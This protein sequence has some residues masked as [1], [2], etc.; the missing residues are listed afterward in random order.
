MING[1]ALWRNADRF[2]GTAPEQRLRFPPKPRSF[3][4][5]GF[6]GSLSLSFQ[7]LSFFTH[8]SRR[9]VDEIRSCFDQN[10]SLYFD[11]DAF[12]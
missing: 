12:S 8:V 2:I 6:Q 7:A 4:L 10:S 11:D 5:F 3:K 9:R 1:G